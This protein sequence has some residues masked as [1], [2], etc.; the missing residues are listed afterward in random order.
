MLQQLAQAFILIRE[1]G[2]LPWPMADY[3][4]YA[5]LKLEPHTYPD[6]LPR[7]AFAKWFYGVFFRWALPFNQNPM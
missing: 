7:G 1:N 2:E 4:C 6:L 5:W 3:T